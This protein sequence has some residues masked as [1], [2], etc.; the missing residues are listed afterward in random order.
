[1]I[2]ESVL[3][4]L[5]LLYSVAQICEKVKGNV[6]RVAVRAGRV[7]IIPKL[8]KIISFHL[9]GRVTA[10]VARLHVPQIHVPLSSIRQA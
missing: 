8:R 3:L 1:M 5:P 9:R 4:K 6:G 2:L 7:L 10:F